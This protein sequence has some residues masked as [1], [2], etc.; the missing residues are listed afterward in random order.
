MGGSG[1]DAWVLLPLHLWGPHPEFAPPCSPGLPP[2]S[3]GPGKGKWSLLALGSRERAWFLPCESRRS[4]GESPRCSL[5]SFGIPM[6]G[7]GEHRVPPCLHGRHSCPW[8]ARVW[9]SKT[10]HTFGTRVRYSS[11]STTGMRHL[12]GGAWNWVSKG[13]KLGQGRVRTSWQ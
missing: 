7:P 9:G 10:P 12:R 11:T 6:W 1:T 13:V 4:L 8:L 5:P 2:L 3:P